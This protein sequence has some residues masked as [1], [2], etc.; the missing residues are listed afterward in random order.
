L[1]PG[2]IS[3]PGQDLVT[4]WIVDWGDG[5][6]ETI[7]AGDALSHVYADGPAQPLI[8]VSAIDE[9]G[10]YSVDEFA[11]DVLN[12]PP[13]ITSLQSDLAVADEGSLFT[14]SGTASDPAGDAD[15]LTYTWLF[16]DDT[17]LPGGVGLTEVTHT[18]ADNGDYV[19]VMLVNDEDD[20]GML[21][22]ITVAVNNVAPD[23]EAGPYVELLPPS[24]GLLARAGI[25]F[26]D[27]GADQ[28]SG[29][30]DFG[31]GSGALPLPIDQLNKTLDLHHTYTA[32]GTY[33]VTVTLQDDDGGIQTDSFDVTVSLAEIEFEA[34]TFEDSEANA[35]STVVTLV[36][37]PA[38]ANVTSRVLVT[39]VGG[40][41][42]GGGT[43]YDDSGFP[44][45]VSFAPGEFRRSIPIPIQRERLVES[46]ET[47]A[48]QVTAVENALI[49]EQAVATLNII[50]DDAAEFIVGSASGA[51]DAGPILFTV[52][53]SN[54]VDLATRVDLSTGDGSALASD[55]DYAA[56]TD[57]TLIFPAGVTSQRFEVALT[58]DTKVEPHETFV[59][60]LA[61][62]VDGGRAVTAS[63]A[64]AS[65]TI[66]NDD[67]LTGR[68]F[69][70]R[71]NDGLYEPADGDQG[72]GGV[73]V[74][75]LD[76]QSTAVIDMQ[77]TDDDGVYTFNVT[78]Q[79]GTYRIVEAFDKP[80]T[81]EVEDELTELGMLD[82]RETPGVNGGTVDNTQNSNAIADIGVGGVGAAA[83]AVDYLFAELL[84]ASLQ[85]LVWEDFDNQGDV[86]LTEIA[87]DGAPVRLT[88]TDDRGHA[89]DLTQ[90]TDAQGMFEFIDLRPGTYAITETQ[91]TSVSGVSTDFV[92]GQEVLGE[93]VE[94]EPPAPAVVLGVDG[95]VG[96][97]EGDKFSLIVLVAGSQGVNYNFG[98]RVDGGTLTTGQTATIGFWQNKNGQALIKSLNGSESSTLLAGWL[99]DTFPNM[100]GS[101]FTVG[102]D[103]TDV[104]GTYKQLFKR[105][106]KTSP[107]GPPK[108]DAQVM[109]VAMAT[110]LTKE[111]LV[112]L[113]YNPADPAN[114]TTD[115][116]LIAGVESY[117]F[118]VTVGG[119]GSTFF[120]VGDSGL[121]FGVADNS[122]MQIIDLLLATDRMS[123]A[124]LLYDDAD[125]DDTGDGEIDDF[126]KL[127]RTLANDV[128]TAINEQGH[129]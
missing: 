22:T 49:E 126:E 84:P 15:T 75:L 125:E 106:G 6:Q 10:T 99:A 17:D 102:M 51:E 97:V 112:S 89:V 119:L 116:S 25:P 58:A 21:D 13:E 55:A 8:S 79:A 82:G 129:I 4:A 123:L 54:P 83:G 52:T 36:R 44:M 85:G 114:P 109:A 2:A 61:N 100:Y 65:G 59:V 78:L 66:L 24:G 23:F 118:D 77:T 46:D 93:V 104:A 48:F 122:R 34:A 30:V 95:V 94:R 72:I 91:P 26:T 60:S 111:S 127:L 76:Q 120:N 40:T 88:G 70:D 32:N 80:N 43:D 41:A 117:G 86:D 20:S 90:T 128:Y 47:I 42:I 68:V 50:N 103:N 101:V 39:I 115:A 7:Q 67:F 33:T 16:N 1:T 38:D 18:F 124:G 45:E 57:N 37:S 28:W 108:L 64:T 69:D 74:Q 11:I 31:D 29:T 12:S 71:D 35:M 53:L 110:Y 5:H 121:A 9:D 105:N 113:S 81:T 92:D 56:V 19:V 62:V 96:P 27:P 87:I 73:P 98:E 107:G 3:D 14:F 63:S